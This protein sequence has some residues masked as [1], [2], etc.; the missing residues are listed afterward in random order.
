MESPWHQG[1]NSQ[2]QLRVSL[3]LIYVVI[4]FNAV[5][6]IIIILIATSRWI[7]DEPLVTVGDAAASFIESPDPRT[8]G[9]CLTSARD[10]RNNKPFEEISQTVYHPQRRRWFSAGSRFRWTIASLL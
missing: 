4:A 5:K 8:K 7:N 2:C 6:L 9:V 1:L 10:I 3:N